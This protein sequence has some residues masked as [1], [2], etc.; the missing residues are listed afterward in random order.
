VL[1]CEILLALLL[2]YTTYVSVS[3][4]DRW[5]PD[6]LRASSAIPVL[7]GPA[8]GPG[9]S[10]QLGA[11]ASVPAGAA[12]YACVASALHLNCHLDFLSGPRRVTRCSPVAHR[13]VSGPA[14]VAAWLCS[15]GSAAVGLC[16]GAQHPACAAVP[17][18]LAGRSSASC[19]TC[20]APW[21]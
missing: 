13:A 5:G 15:L 10:L 18:L 7:S 3:R 19:P 16:P 12:M 6:T 4:V 17:R 20:A 11:G 14:A 21:Q 8:R 2:K 9:T 1:G